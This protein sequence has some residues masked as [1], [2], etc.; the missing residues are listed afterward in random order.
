[1]SYL[2]ILQKTFEADNYFVNKSIINHKKYK[3]RYNVLL[4]K[5]NDLIQNSE[6]DIKEILEIMEKLDK[7]I[8]LIGGNDKE[9]LEGYNLDAE[10]K[11]IEINIDN[12]ILANE[13]IEEIERDVWILIKLDYYKKSN[14]CIAI[15]ER[16]YFYSF[17]NI[18][19]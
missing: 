15:F 10:I 16:P 6:A 18:I 11:A 9:I 1:M 5:Y 14:I 7:G 2:S 8:N 13:K 12:M 4:K 17:A 3:E 19:N